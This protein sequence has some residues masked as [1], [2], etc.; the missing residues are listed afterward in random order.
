MAAVKDCQVTATAVNATNRG[1]SVGPGGGGRTERDD[2]LSVERGGACRSCTGHS[3]G[4]SGGDCLGGSVRRVGDC[5]RGVAD[6][7]SRI[8]RH[9]CLVVT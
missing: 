2:W 7:E 9:G 4:G 3:V 6:G 5:R 1:Y 8:E